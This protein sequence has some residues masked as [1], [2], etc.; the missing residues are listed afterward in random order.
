[1]YEVYIKKNETLKDSKELYT[2]LP[3]LKIVVNKLALLLTVPDEVGCTKG[4]LSDP[5]VIKTS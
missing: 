2:E 5:I 3:R 4:G 1:M